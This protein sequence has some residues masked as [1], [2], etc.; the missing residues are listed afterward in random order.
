MSVNIHTLSLGTMDNFIYIIE[1]EVTKKAMVVDAA[2][3]ADAIL[4]YLYANDLI[5]SGIL[6]THTHPD[7]TSAIN[8]IL[9][10]HDIPVC[11]SQEE[12]HIGLFKLEQPTFVSDGEQ[13]V[14]GEQVIDV[15]ATPGHTVGSLCYHV[16]EHLIVGDTLFIDGCGR[17]NFVESDVNQMYD[18]L[19]RLKSLSDDTII[20]CGHDYGQQSKDTLGNQ[21]R[22]NPYLLIDDSNFFVAFRMTLQSKYRSIPFTPSSAEFMQTIYQTHKDELTE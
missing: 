9:E 22:T 11:I 7:H 10:N 18:S 14:L 8:A 19:Q 17:C 16:G 1:D 21:K 4:D 6:L 2:W 3:D 5:L 20:Y 13:I 15:I 12:F